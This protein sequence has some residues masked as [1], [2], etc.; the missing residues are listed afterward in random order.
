MNILNWIKKK[1]SG[2]NPTKVLY[3]TKYTWAKGGGPPQGRANW[4]FS[5]KESA[6]RPYNK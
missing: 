3:T 4:L 1:S 2:L 6:L 5:A